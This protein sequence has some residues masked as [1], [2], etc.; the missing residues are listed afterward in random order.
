MVMSSFFH[1][2]DVEASNFTFS[3][4]E[5]KFIFTFLY[6]ELEKYIFSNKRI[7]LVCVCV[8]KLMA[9]KTESFL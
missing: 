8:C 1:R 4:L 9:L 5:I 2:N 3:F 6:Q 7:F